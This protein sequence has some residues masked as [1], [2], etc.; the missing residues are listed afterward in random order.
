MLFLEKSPPMLTSMGKIEI[1]L[2]S[3]VVQGQEGPGKLNRQRRMSARS[4]LEG[5]RLA[6]EDRMI[7]RDPDIGFVRPGPRNGPI[8]R[9]ITRPIPPGV[10][11]DHGHVAK[12]RLLVQGSP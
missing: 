7:G 1:L 8:Q 10:G 4:V 9:T 5:V 6:D 12:K 11:N 2:R 3:N